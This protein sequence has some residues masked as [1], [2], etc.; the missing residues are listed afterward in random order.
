MGKDFVKIKHDKNIISRWLALAEPNKWVWFWQTFFYV[1]Y[2]ILLT[3]ITIFSA[4]VISCLYAS[5]WAGAYLNLAI[6]LAT[7]IGRNIAI[8]IQNRFYSEHLKIT[9]GNAAQKVYKKIMS[10]ESKG[11]KSITKDKIINIALNNMGDLSA[12]PNAV[13]A[14]LAYLIQVVVVLVA[15]FSANVLAGVIVV[16]LG[17]INFLAYLVFNKKL[18][19]IKIEKCE[20]K[21]RVFSEYN[22]VID[23]KGVITELHKDAKYEDILLDKININSDAT[24]HYNMVSS[25]KTNLWFAVWNTVVYGIT[26]LLIFFVSKG[27]LEIGI[28][29]IIAPYLTTCT[30]KLITLFDKSA[31]LENMR[32]DV[33]RINMILGLTD[34]ELITYGNNNIE[35]KGY[36]LALIDAKY[37][38]TN[39][40]YE[41][42]LEAANINFNMLDVN[43]IEGAKGSGKR[44]IFNMLR[45][46]IKPDSGRVVLDNLDLYDYNEVTFKNHINYASVHPEFVSGSIKDN[47]DLASTNFND[48]KKVCVS[49][50]I[51]SII[52]KLE[53]GYNTKISEVKSSYLLFMLSIARGL[54]TKPNIFMI[55]S[56]PQDL[57]GAQVEK[58]KKILLKLKVERTVIIFTHDDFFNDIAGARFRVTRG[59]VTK[60]K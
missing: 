45:R 24:T 37:D 18:A 33:D 5:D 43:V 51:N 34:K 26:A 53:A 16:V 32:V 1:V 20:T 47:L 55:Y 4:R 52:E 38:N 54:L 10:C 44:V 17:V 46:R 59:K 9:S 60:K 48:I 13:S 23:N 35:S 49:L 40:D 3:I 19:K 30:E 58:I 21:E 29:L 31:A 39:E 14:F 25:A 36:N 6:A 28:Y 56:L 8:H 42:T 12:F 11:L 22:N 50:G 15:V 7:L 27:E 2:T 57:T 41:G